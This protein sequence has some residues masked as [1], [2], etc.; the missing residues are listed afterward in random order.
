M[1]EIQPE[2]IYLRSLF[3]PVTHIHRPTHTHTHTHTHARAR[4]HVHAHTHTHT[5][6][7]KHTNILALWFK[8]C[9]R[10]SYANIPVSYPF[11][12]AK[13][14]DTLLISERT[15]FLLSHLISQFRVTK[16]ESYLYTM[17]HFPTIRWPTRRYGRVSADRHC[18]VLKITCNDSKFKRK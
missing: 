17:K 9:L 12:L 1:T 18:T 10:I 16:Y 6:T 14:A 13:S 15:C 4:A 7:H 8:L 3:K 5:H 11:C 2:V